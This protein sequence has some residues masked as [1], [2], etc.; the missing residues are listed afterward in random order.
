MGGAGLHA[1]GDEVCVVVVNCLLC[2]GY[3]TVLLQPI[4][5]LCGIA[6]RLADSTPCREAFFSLRGFCPFTIVG[7]A[8][9]LISRS[10]HGAFEGAMTHISKR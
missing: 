3:E 7:L 1:V 6:Q 10:T 5:G 9:F 8:Q 4:E 2:A